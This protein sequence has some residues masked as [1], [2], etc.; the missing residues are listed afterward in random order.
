[1]DF[2]LREPPF[3]RRYWWYRGKTNYQ[4]PVEHRECSGNEFWG[5][6]DLLLPQMSIPFKRIDAKDIVAVQPMA[7]PASIVFYDKFKVTDS[8]G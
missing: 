2:D 8:K 5:W 6:A 1:M 3:I 7:H 4:P